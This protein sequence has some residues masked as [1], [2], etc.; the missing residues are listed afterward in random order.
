MNRSWLPLSLLLFG[1]LFPIRAQIP[2]QSE[3]IVPPSDQVSESSA[4]QELA[5]ALEKLGKLEAAKS[6][7]QKLLR[8]RPG[9][10][11]LY[12]DLADVEAARG[13][14]RRSRD[15]YQQALSKSNQNRDLLLRYARQAST[16]GDFYLAERI[17]RSHLAEHPRDV[18]AALDLASV[19]IGE[20]QYEAAE[21]EYR[22]LTREPRAR[23]R[24]FIGLATSHLLKQ[25]F[26][27]VLPLTEEV[28]KVNPDQVEA[29]SLRAEALRRL[30]RYDDAKKEFRQLST[31]PAGRLSGWTGLGQV[32]RA[33]RD[34]M[35][36][37]Q[38]FRRAQESDPR[39]IRARYLLA[40]KHQT[41]VEFARSI[42]G[43]PDLTAAD[44]NTLA[45]LYAADRSLD[46][47]IATYQA[48]LNRDPDYFPAR[49][50]LAQ[51][52]ATAHRYDQSIELLTRL[53]AEFPGNAKIVLALARVLSWSRRYD[54]AMRVYRDLTVLNPTDTVPP[55][56]MA[57][58]AT[59]RK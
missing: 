13:H 45:G 26:H 57:R 10:P 16:W 33:Q 19:L 46:S 4:R 2:V 35:A 47:A 25:D 12:A 31:L 52:L 34:E 51:S 41:S 22:S 30:H 18:D 1:A 28:L 24:A 8:I 55:K 49:L 7:L 14:A 42:V 17:L 21:V 37:E 48:A 50:G 59:W 15:L 54:D 9:D 36:A 44:L 32:A 20:E 39:D 23:Q 43:W 6:E 5:R 29:I 11:F 38:Y 53:Q 27:A 40:N 56:E 3:T 58:V